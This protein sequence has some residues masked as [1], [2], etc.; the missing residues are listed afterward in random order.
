M[1]VGVSS[2]NGMQTGRCEG[3]ARWDSGRAEH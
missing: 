1:G 2:P 3:S